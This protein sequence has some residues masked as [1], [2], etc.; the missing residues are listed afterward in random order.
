MKIKPPVKQGDN[1]VMQISGLGSSGEGVGKY[2][3]FTV[4]VKG[5][6]PE[7]EVRVKITLVKKSYAIGELQEVVKPSAERIEPACPVYKE[8]GGCQ[9]Q[10]LSYKGQLECKREQV[11]AA[12]GRIGHLDIEVLPV[13]GANDPWNIATRCSSR[14]R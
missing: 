5:A 8:C 14:Q 7:E 12:L 9:L 2:E 4:F 6:L 10:H 1:I 13:L 3:G 11:Q